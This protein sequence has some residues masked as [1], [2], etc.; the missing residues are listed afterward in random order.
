MI[1][2]Q[3]VPRAMHGLTGNTPPSSP[4]CPLPRQ[5]ISQLEHVLRV[6]PFPDPQPVGGA[7]PYPPYPPPIAFMH[8]WG[9]TGPIIPTG[10]KIFFSGNQ[11]ALPRF[12]KTRKTFVCCCCSG[13]SQANPAATEFPQGYWYARNARCG[14]SFKNKPVA[15]RKSLKVGRPFT[16]QCTNSLTGL[17]ERL[18]D[19]M[20]TGDANWAHVGHSFDNVGESAYPV[21]PSAGAYPP[22]SEMLS[23]TRFCLTE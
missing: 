19:R 7:Y 1:A 5:P 10:G 22:V 11:K 14:R 3:S 23:H 20:R 21:A 2:S 6:Q 12:L 17:D 8:P 13:D 4:N 9:L 15:L 16:L 18:E